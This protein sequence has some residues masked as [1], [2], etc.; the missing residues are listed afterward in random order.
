MANVSEFVIWG[1]AP[2]SAHEALL[3]SEYAGIRDEDHAKQI[4]ATLAAEHGCT[5]MR[6]QKLAPLCDA[7]EVSR[8]FVGAL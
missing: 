2:N 3:V 5:D 4:V 7:A 6:I 8:M 1:K